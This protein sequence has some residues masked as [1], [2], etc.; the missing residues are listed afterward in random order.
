MPRGLCEVPP[1]GARFWGVCL[2]KPPK[3]SGATSLPAGTGF[4][5]G[6]A[7]WGPSGAK[8]GLPGQAC[9]PS[10]MCQ[11]A[12]PGRLFGTKPLDQQGAP[13]GGPRPLWLQFS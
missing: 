8:A 10:G 7:P 12:K 3:A 9:V 4:G 5:P 1:K 6:R 13:E 11:V 2:G